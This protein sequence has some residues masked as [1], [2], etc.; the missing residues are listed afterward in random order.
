MFEMI[1]IMAW[2]VGIVLAIL[3]L[4]LPWIIISKMDEMIDELRRINNKKVV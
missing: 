2:V 4:F 3:W 1:I